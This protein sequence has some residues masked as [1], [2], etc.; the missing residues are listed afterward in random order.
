[1]KIVIS[2][3]TARYNILSIYPETCS[4]HNKQF[5]SA[6]DDHTKHVVII[7]DILFHKQ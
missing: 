6:V 1:M 4:A 3:F 7:D 2:I 5:S